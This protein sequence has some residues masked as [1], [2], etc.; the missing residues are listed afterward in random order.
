MTFYFRP[1]VCEQAYSMAQNLDPNS[2][3]R[4]V[5]QF[6]TGLMSIIKVMVADFEG[7]IEKESF[8]VICVFY[9]LFDFWGLIIPLA[10]EFHLTI[11]YSKNLLKREG[12]ELIVITILK[13]CGSFINATSDNIEWMTSNEKSRDC[14]SLELLALHWESMSNSWIFSFLNRQICS[15]FIQW[16]WWRLFI[17]FSVTKILMLIFKYGI[18]LFFSMDNIS[19]CFIGYACVC[20]LIWKWKFKAWSVHFDS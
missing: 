15:L 19:T 1:S 4:G 8:L 3:G 7:Y 6:K 13:T 2:D 9:F 14:K 16:N 10:N 17:R 5:L 12:F 11:F 18:G 20:M